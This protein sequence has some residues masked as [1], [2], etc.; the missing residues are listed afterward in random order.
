MRRPPKPT[1]DRGGRFATHKTCRFCACATAHRRIA[2]SAACSLR[3]YH[4]LAA[5]ADSVMAWAWWRFVST[6]SS[7]HSSIVTFDSRS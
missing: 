5:G 7:Q 1:A 4:A 3:Q 6:F 2:A